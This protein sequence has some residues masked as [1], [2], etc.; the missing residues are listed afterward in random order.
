MDFII[1]KGKAFSDRDAYQVTVQQAQVLASHW[2]ALRR[3][4]QDMEALQQ[5]KA[6]LQTV[7]AFLN[8]GDDA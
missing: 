4:R 2:Q 6:V 3:C 1:E 7:R 8:E 5:Q